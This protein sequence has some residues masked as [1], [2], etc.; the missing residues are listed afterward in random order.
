MLQ[1]A[2]RLRSPDARNAEPLSIGTNGDRQYVDQ[3]CAFQNRQP[4][5]LGRTES[6]HG[7]AHGHPLIRTHPD[8]GTKAIWFHK[9]K[10]ETVSGLNSQETQD[11]CGTLLQSAIKPEFIYLH[12]LAFR[13]H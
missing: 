1:H 11:L 9:S 7:T 6:L 4:G 13:R 8:N 3:Q 10:T 12:E 2:R 5:H